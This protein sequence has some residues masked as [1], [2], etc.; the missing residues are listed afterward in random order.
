MKKLMVAM[1]AALSMCAFADEDKA[2]ETQDSPILWGS[3][4]Y[5]VYSGYQLY[6]SL[7]NREPTMQGYFE[8]NANLPNDFGYLGAGLWS[9]SDLTAQRK[10]S[11]GRIFNEFDFNAHWGKTFY[12]DDDKAWGLEYRA[13]VVWFYYPHHLYQR[14]EGVYNGRVKVGTATTVDFDHSFALVNPYLIPYVTVV[15]EYHENK[16][17]LLQFGVR[18]P[19]QVND[20][21]SICPFVEGV[22][23]DDRYNW[24][25]PTR[26]GMA[27]DGTNGGVATLKLELDATY[28]ITECFGIFAKVAYC[29]VVDPDLRDNCDILDRAEYGEKKDYAWGGVGVSFRF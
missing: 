8:V 12:F 1:A 28:Q 24:C 29:S 23:R 21:L 22:W 2:A 26:F 6:G 25:F 19:I 27:N 5:G 10:E 17:N 9:N 4:S 16:A 18:K 3:G 14:R 11:Y 7:V 20:Q 15:R 13:S